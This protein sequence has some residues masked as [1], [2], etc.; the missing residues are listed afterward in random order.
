MDAVADLSAEGLDRLDADRDPELP[1]RLLVALERAPPRGLV[2]GVRR[3][4]PLRELVEG[5]RTAGVEQ[6][7][8][9]VD[10][11]LQPLAHAHAA[12]AR[13]CAARTP[14]A[15]AACEEHRV[16]CRRP[17]HRHDVEAVRV[18]QR[19]HVR[20]VDLDHL[21]ATV[22]ARC[23]EIG[24][25]PCLL[26]AADA[27][28]RDADPFPARQPEGGGAVMRE[29]EVPLAWSA[30]DARSAAMGTPPSATAASRIGPTSIPLKPSR[31][32]VPTMPGPIA[33]TATS[34]RA[35]WRA[36]ASAEKID[37]AS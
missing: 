8:G 25:Q 9:Q 4:Q 7:G 27:R 33:T 32:L 11:T 3:L 26:V 36:T 22:E 19:E 24:A 37:T 2:V 28:E 12:P 20:R 18:E 14:A 21:V 10:E 23:G 34:A 35:T 5:Q 29:T 30:N 13:G 15:A 17:S 16:G 1:H 31:V 6:R